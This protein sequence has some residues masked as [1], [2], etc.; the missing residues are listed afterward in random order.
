MISDRR[1]LVLEGGGPG[2]Y[3]P[4]AM[5][6]PTADEA[7]H[8]DA[9]DLC[10][11]PATELAAKIRARQIS[12]VEAVE[13]VLARIEDLNPRLN[14]FCFVHAD[15]ARQL[16]RAAEAAVLRGD[17]L[18][19]LHGVPVSV[20]DNVAIEGKPLTYGSRLLRDNVAR[21]TSPIGARIATSGAIV[22]GRTNTP[23]YAWRGSTD[24]RLFGETRNPWDLTRTA[25]GSSGGAGAA[26]AAGLTPL[27]LGT[28]GAGSIRIPASFC[29]IVGHKPSFGRVPFFPSPGANELAAHAGPMTRTVRDAALFLDVLSGPDDRDRF[30]LPAPSERY[31]ESVEGGVEGWRVAW[32]PDLGHIPVEPEVRQIAESAARSFADLGAHVDQPDLGLPDPEPLLGVLYPFVQAAAHAARLPEEQAEMDPGLVAIAQQGAQLSAVQVGQ[33]MAAR[34]AYWDRMC[35]AFE[36]FDVLLTPTI[37][38]PA[39]ELGIVGPTEVAARS[40]VHLGWTLA[41]PFNFTGQPAATVPCGFTQSGLPVGLQV[42]GRRYADGAVLR[43][44]A[45]FEAA[46]PWAAL[47]PP[48]A[49]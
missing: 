40:V 12:P 38:V 27:S 23:E 14:A 3:S 15:E 5:P 19:P 17:D 46:R 21:E 39:F 9:D 10:F 7:H 43:A 37:S 42:V 28:D 13:A 49:R 41:Y 29:G 26:V 22:V 44:A 24:N 30:S 33:A 16:A 32:S 47:R 35:R 36:Q 8:T 1:H 4:R 2:C 6:P 48:V 18:G 34:A 25:G 31:V 20:K 11:L 45:A